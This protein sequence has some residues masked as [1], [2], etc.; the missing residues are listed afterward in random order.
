MAKK[1]TK[2]TKAMTRTDILADLAESTEL[3]KK[4]V[5]RVIDGLADLI[6]LHVNKRSV[7]TFTLPGLLKVKVVATPARKAKKNVPNPFRPGETMDV[8][9][10][11]AGRKV[12]ILAL[13][14]LKDMAV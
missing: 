6:E 2:L 5:G 3:T 13:K 1:A 14:K 11:P 8:A 4:D 12:K 7:G 10:R 9:A